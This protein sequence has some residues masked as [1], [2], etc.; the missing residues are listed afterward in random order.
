M[1]AAEPSA[2][3]DAAAAGTAVVVLAAGSGR[4][5][6]LG[7][8]AHV[9]LGDGT[10]LSRIVDGCR[11]AGLRSIYV[12]GS[13]SDAH[14]RRVCAE[15]G[16]SLTLNLD[17]ERGMSSSVH[18]GLAAASRASA[19]RGILVV[20]VDV[21]IVRAES[22]R[23]LAYALERVPDGWVRPVWRGTGGHPVGL[24]GRLVPRILARGGVAPLRDA[25]R[26]MGAACVDVPCDDPGVVTDVDLPEDLEAARRIRV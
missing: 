6:G 12:V 3:G 1:D 17:P 9:P 23:I 22:L 7:P 20:P 18:L 11:A 8:K 2:R 24:G 19:E 16:A 13:V 25:L 4:R 21:P 5:L 15:L 14:I 26:D 10:F